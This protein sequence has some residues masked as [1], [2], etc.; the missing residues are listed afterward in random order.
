MTSIRRLALPVLLAAAGSAHAA[1]VPV[2][3]F[4]KDPEWPLLLA[5]GVAERE[6]W[7]RED[8]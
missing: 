3:D 1:E 2:G 6:G 4:F 7:K 8:Q 5:E